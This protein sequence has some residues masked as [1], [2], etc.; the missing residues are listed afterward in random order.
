[1]VVLWGESRGRGLVY[2]CLQMCTIYRVAGVSLMEKLAQTYLKASGN[3]P[4]GYLREES[5]GC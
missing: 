3:E 5:S 1:M 4:C 2:V